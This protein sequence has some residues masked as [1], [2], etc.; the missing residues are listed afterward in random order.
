M[1]WRQARTTGNGGVI[2]NS[3]DGNMTTRWA[4]EGT[5]SAAW[6][7]YDLGEVKTLDKVQLAFYNGDSRVYTFSIAVSED[8]Q[9][10]TTVLNKQKSSG[11][12]N[13][14]EV[15]DLGGAKAR[16]VKYMGGGNTVNMWNSVNELVLTE[17][18]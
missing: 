6:A 10:Y 1:R 5:E 15:F 2:T 7:V 9:N 17:K 4:A 8:G 11:T 18:K 3:I 12:T 14:F 13:E 16:Y